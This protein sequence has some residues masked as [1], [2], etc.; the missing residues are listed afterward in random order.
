MVTHFYMYR[1]FGMIVEH[2]LRNTFIIVLYL[3]CCLFRKPLHI[4]YVYIAYTNVMQMLR[5]RHL[6]RVC[7]IFVRFGAVPQINASEIYRIC[8]TGM[9]R[10]VVVYGRARVLRP[11]CLLVCLF[12]CLYQLQS[13]YRWTNIYVG[14]YVYIFSITV[15]IYSILFGSCVVVSRP[16]ACITYH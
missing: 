15:G 5:C 8:I 9:R 7:V 16:C 1:A 4:Y 13:I 10:L 3:I 2:T 12:F 6:L 14:M 11:V